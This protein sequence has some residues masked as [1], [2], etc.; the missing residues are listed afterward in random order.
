MEAL[1]RAGQ[2]DAE[3][4]AKSVSMFEVR[5]FDQGSMALITPAGFPS[6][7]ESCQPVQRGN[8]GGR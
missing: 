8:L 7:R 6:V 1:T 5:R 2:Y 3:L 4:L